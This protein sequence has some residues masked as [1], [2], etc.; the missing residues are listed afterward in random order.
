M[1]VNSGVL[2]GASGRAIYLKSIARWDPRPDYDIIEEVDR[3]RGWENIREAFP[4]QGHE[5]GR[6]VF[7]GISSIS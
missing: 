7:S 4:F 1:F 3:N 5:I 2:I 6:A